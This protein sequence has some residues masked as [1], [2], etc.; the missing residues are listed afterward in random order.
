MYDNS[1]KGV[2]AISDN[3]S[4]VELAFSAKHLFSNLGDLAV[5][6]THVFG[7]NSDDDKSKIIQIRWDKGIQETFKTLGD[8]V[9]GI[10][11]GKA[12][13]RSFEGCPRG[14]GMDV[15]R[16]SARR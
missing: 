11:I 9:T 7:L 5:N 15:T 12:F 3:G 1:T 4:E 2:Y 6:A 13:G 8:D 16:I 14:G 10:S